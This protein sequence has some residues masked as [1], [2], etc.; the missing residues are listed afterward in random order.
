VSEGK[1]ESVHEVWVEDR[2]GRYAILKGFG[3]EKVERIIEIIGR[4]DEN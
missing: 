3:L 2:R 4:D 1:V